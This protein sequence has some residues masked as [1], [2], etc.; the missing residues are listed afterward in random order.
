MTVNSTNVA[1]I[2]G[3]GSGI[4]RAL[5]LQYA[6]KG[7]QVVVSGRRDEK[8]RQTRALGPTRLIDV[9]VCDVTKR[10]Q[11]ESCVQ[12][13][14]EQFGRLD[15]VIANAGYAQSGKLMKLTECDWKRQFHVNVYGAAN[16]AS[17]AMPHLMNSKGQ[18]VFVSSVMAY[19]RFAGSGAYSASKA[20]LTA[21]AESYMLEL[22]GTGVS[23]SVVHPGFIES[24]I[25]QIDAKGKYDANARD[26]R[27]QKFMWT[28]Q[29]AASFIQRR[30]DRRCSHI[31]VTWHGFLGLHLS[32][33]FPRF[34]LWVQQRLVK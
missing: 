5:A 2:T 9:F 1:W 15:I 28:A 33:I 6:M 8:L 25:G 4:G 14:I 19:L 3:G 18:V 30:L 10:E 24:E 29:N 17:V 26:T 23:C 34:T 22:V 11:V 12:H 32:R 27:P 13:I 21:L 16:T 20:A 7:W 31:T